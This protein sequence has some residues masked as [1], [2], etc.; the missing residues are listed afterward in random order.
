MKMKKILLGLLLLTLVLLPL[1]ALGEGGLYQVSTLQALMQGDYYGTVSVGT[2]LAQGDTGLGTF[3]GLDGEMIVLDGVAYKAA[4]DGSVT[5]MPADATVPFANVAFLGDAEDMETSFEG[6]Y[7][8]L[9]AALNFC[10]PDENLPV[11]FVVT[12]TFTGVTVRSVPKQEEPYPPLTEAVKNQAVFTADTVEGTI[13]G[14]RFPDY[15][16]EIN[17]TGY[18]LHFLSADHTFGGHLLEVQSGTVTVQAAALHEFHMVLPDTIRL[19]NPVDTTA[20]DTE[21]VESGAN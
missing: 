6:G 4:V 3:D 17:T 21:L 13:V 1:Q 5:P 15:L 7:D 19:Y 2:L 16:G 12:G 9:L 8:A 20:S 10:A 18:H 14:F 11:I